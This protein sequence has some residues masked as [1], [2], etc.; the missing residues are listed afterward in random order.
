MS[1][2]K[3]VL[4]DMDGVLID[5]RD[6]HYEALNMAL[7][8]FGYV[9]NRESHLLSFDGLSTRQKLVKLSQAYGLP[10]QLHDFINELKQKFTQE[11]IASRC[12]P[13]FQHRYVLA[14]LKREGYHLALCSN[15][16]RASIDV[17]CEKAGLAEFLEFTLSNEDVSK[18][19]PDPEIYT[20]AIQRLGLNPEEC[21]IVED[22]ENGITSAKASHAHVLEVSCPDDVTYQLIIKTIKAIT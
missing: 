21:L 10:E 11:L 4:F 9:I 16:I 18:A 20:K 12:N 2:I 3:A 13:T 14:R 15:S 19:K 8:P 17:M 22:N 1:Q 6:W 5:A 7:A